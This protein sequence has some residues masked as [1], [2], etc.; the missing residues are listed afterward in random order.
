MKSDFKKKSRRK[1]RGHGSSKGKTCGRGHKGQKCRSG[2][3]K[4]G[5]KERKVLIKRGGL[6]CG[7]KCRR[8][9]D[10]NIKAISLSLLSK[11]LLANSKYSVDNLRAMFGLNRF[12]YVKILDGDINVIGLVLECDYASDS[13]IIKISN[14]GGKI[15]LSNVIPHKY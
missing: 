2:G 13:A 15:V 6:E 14:L 9:S 5:L 12:C 11:R 10:N 7:F 1:G 8:N 3:R 4:H